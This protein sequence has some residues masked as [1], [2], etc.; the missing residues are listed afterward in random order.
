MKADIGRGRWFA[1]LVLCA[2]SVGLY[3]CGTYQM[4]GVVVE[5]AVSMIRVVDEDDPRLLEGNGLPM[6][7]IDATLDAERLSRKQ[8]TRDISD[9]DGTF[10]VSV[11]ETGAG[12]L[13]YYARVVVRRTGYDTA[14]QDIRIPGP[15][16]RLLVT[17]ARGQDSY[18]PEAPDV[19]DETLE[20]GHPY[21]R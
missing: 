8:L 11:D 10:R 6:A 5:G 14:V 7:T 2:S 15:H 18:K 16:Q 17:L 13:D 21:M 3:G 19:V 9:V 12:Y 20:M 1:L 4:Q